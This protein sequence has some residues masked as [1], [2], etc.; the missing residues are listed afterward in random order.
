MAND[1][2]G[3]ASARATEAAT[4]AVE[5]LSVR[6][7]GARAHGRSAEELVMAL[8]TSLEVNRHLNSE[9]E[10]LM[11]KLAKLEEQL[12]A[13]EA[14]RA[15]VGQ[16]LT[17]SR[18]QAAG[19]LAD[20]PIMAS[21]G[22]LAREDPSELTSAEKGWEA[23][24]QRGE[25]VGWLV[26]PSTVE[27][28]AAVAKGTFGTTHRGVWRGGQ[29]AVKAV[30]VESAQEAV[31]FLR[32]IEIMSCVRHPNVLPFIGAVLQPPE[33]CWV[34][35]EWMG[36]GTLKAW[37]HG[38]RAAGV[39]RARHKLSARLRKA[40]EVARGM[41]ALQEAEP[42]V[43]HRDL[44]PSNVL[45]DSSGAARVADMG[46]ARRYTVA[47]SGVLTG[48]TGT[49]LYMA[50]EVLRHDPYDTKADVFSWA[51]LAAELVTQR[52]PY[53]ETYM[54]PMQVALAVASNNLRPALPAW[55]HPG[56][57]KLLGSAWDADTTKRPF[58]REIVRK[59]S[60][61]VEHVELDEAEAEEVAGGS[62]PVGNLLRGF[63]WG[64][65]STAAAAAAAGSSARR[66]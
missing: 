14:E 12:R 6:N 29:V 40:L 46:L 27:M 52:V 63:G 10:G 49:Y 9:V 2:A 57:G 32:E 24:R 66:Q 17:E 4:A 33:S 54:T 36:G 51:V 42:P 48:E 39:P 18:R 55:V 15:A 65:R 11:A 38:D 1:P 53:E 7:E 26:D 47:A 5:E 60:K 35:A 19:E 62:N 3:G 58:F 44:K 64:G 50:P 30:L 8:D 45:I 22:A 31:S 20:G 56:V 28:G 41:Q 43:M 13:T 37:L 59:M 61:F 34:L 25:A 21:E 16:K 23:L